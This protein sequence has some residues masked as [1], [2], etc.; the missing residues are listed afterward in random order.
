MRL[1]INHMDFISFRSVFLCE[2]PCPTSFYKLCIPSVFGS[3]YLFRGQAWIVFKDETAATA[4]LN[5][6]QGFVYHGQP[7]VGRVLHPPFLKFFYLYSQVYVFFLVSIY[8]LPGCIVSSLFMVTYWNLFSTSITPSLRATSS[9]R[10]MG[11]LPN[12]LRGLA[13]PAG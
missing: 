11:P 12:D 10:K 6:M 2:L 9:P 13:N 8:V 4:A 7:L 5:G 3:A 1:L